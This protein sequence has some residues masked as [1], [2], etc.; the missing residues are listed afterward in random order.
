M[1]LEWMLNYIAQG[2]GVAIEPIQQ[3]HFCA[4]V[5][6]TMHEYFPVANDESFCCT[7]SESKSA[8]SHLTRT[9]L[10]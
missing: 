8:F 6:R 10:R 9:K 1:R 5:V 2:I 4:N 7:W 3:T